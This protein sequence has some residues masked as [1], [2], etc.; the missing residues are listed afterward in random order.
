M[1]CT[2]NRSSE[3]T[4]AA[5]PRWHAVVDRTSSSSSR[6]RTASAPDRRS[7]VRTGLPAGGKR[8]RTASPSRERVGLS[9]GNERCR[10]GEK[11]S[12]VS[13]SFLVRGTGGSNLVPSSGESA[14]NCSATLGNAAGPGPVHQVRRRRLLRPSRRYW[15]PVNCC[16]SRET[17]GRRLARG[18]NAV[19]GRG[20]RI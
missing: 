6:L 5:A 19:H 7:Q 18:Y 17:D 20:G 15:F 14:T 13:V 1:T 16:G 8:I 11:G 2:T 4:A 10:R 9:G 3:R 12:L